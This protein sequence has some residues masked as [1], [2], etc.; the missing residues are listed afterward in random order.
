MITS[1]S[2]PRVKAVVQLQKKRK[3]REEKGVF[4]VEG[5]RM[6][7]E[8]P[9]KDMLEVYV[10]ESFYK[11]HTQ[12]LVDQGVDL[13]VVSDLVF[14]KISDTKTPQGI[15]SIVR[16]SEYTLEEII[17]HPQANIL[18]LD[19]LQD[20]GN[21]GTI[22]RTGEAAGITG[23]ILTRDTVDLF[24]AKTIRSTMGSIFRMPYIYVDDIVD[25][26]IQIKQKNISIFAAHL[27]GK[28][29]YTD[30]NYS[31]QI[32]LLIGNEGNGLRKEVAE[33]ADTWV[34]IPME[35]EIESLNAAIAA[36]VLMYEV[37]R[38]RRV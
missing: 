24:Q 31:S 36:T 8:I 11:K 5:I 10:S 18:V 23:V 13:E 14:Q 2:N 9:H 16:R 30:V 33:L 28:I 37:Y 35:G 38:Q 17:Q 26:I 29:W 7:Q 6:F 1:I 32:A 21:V 34:R 15:L 12:L 27:D 22:V 25:T 20:P 19:G 3:L 4:I